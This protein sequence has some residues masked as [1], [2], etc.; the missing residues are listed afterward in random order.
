MI[1]QRFGLPPKKRCQKRTFTRTELKAVEHLARLGATNAQIAQYFGVAVN[2]VDEWHKKYRLFKSAMKKGGLEADMKVAESLYKRAIGY[3]YVE[4]EYSAVEVEGQKKP[5]T[6]MALVKKTVKTLPPDVKAA[7]H[8]L[9]VRQREV[10]M[11]VEQQT[12]LHAGHVNHVHQ[13]IQE[14]PIQELSPETQKLVLE[15]AQKQLNP[16]NI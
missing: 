15:I 14:L 1:R 6:E 4:E 16:I 10:W 13:K 9:K 8:W 7:I 11:H 12:I 2:T 3:Q 5:L